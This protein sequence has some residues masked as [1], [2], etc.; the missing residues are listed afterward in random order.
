MPLAADEPLIIIGA[1]GLGLNAVAVLRA[2]GQANIIVV[3]ISDKKRS[4]ALAACA[5]QALDGSGDNAVITRRVLE[6]AG[7]P[8][9]AIIDL[10]NSAVTSRFAFNSLRK[11]GQLVQVG[12]FGGELSIPLPVMALRVLTLRGSYVGSPK[13]LREV[14]K[15]AQKGSLNPMPIT[16]VPKSQ[17][18]AAL[19]NLR[20]GNV[21]GRVV[22][23]A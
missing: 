18:N 3:D 2:M 4:A 16:T 11:G 12:L 8:V 20:T 15:L 21:I 23:T 19:T 7:G 14:L 6:A 1:G 10:V 5:T 13:D 17:V 22:L 9:T